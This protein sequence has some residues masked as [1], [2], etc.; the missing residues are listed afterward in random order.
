MQSMHLNLPQNP[1]IMK[2]PVLCR[3]GQ[4]GV[5]TLV[6]PEL[7]FWIYRIARF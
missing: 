3:F 7:G 1:I 4:S 6:V 2:A 5:D